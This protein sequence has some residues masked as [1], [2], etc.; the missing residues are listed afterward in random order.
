VEDQVLIGTGASV[1]QHLC[2][3]SGAR[4]GAGAIVTKNVESK[5]TVKGVPA[6][7]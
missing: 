5:S 6:K 2:I 3:R 1:L 7:K 4:V